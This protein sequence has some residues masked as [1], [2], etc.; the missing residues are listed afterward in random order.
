MRLNL[1]LILFGAAFACTRAQDNA[2]PAAP[3]HAA[4]LSA[5][6]TQAIAFLELLKSGED[7]AD[8]L[9]RFSVVRGGYWKK[10]QLLT[11]LDT[12]GVTFFDINVDSA[13]HQSIVSIRSTLVRRSGNAFSMLVH[14]GHIYAQPES[15]YSRLQFSEDSLSLVVNVGDWYRLTF[16][17]QGSSFRVATI[18]YVMKEVE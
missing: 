2:P 8:R 13:W 15:Q 7:A 4:V 18:A 1:R 14:L 17:R 10:E 11:L 12:T 3:S 6:T 9:R 16:V 5:D